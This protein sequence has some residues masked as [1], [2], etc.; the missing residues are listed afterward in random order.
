MSFIRIVSLL[1][2]KYV[3]IENVPGMVSLFKGK[4][5]DEII[6]S[7][8]NLGYTV[9]FQI[10]RASEYG[11]P[12][13]RRR[14][15]FIGSKNGEKFEFPLSTHKEQEDLIF[16]KMVSTY[17]AL[18]DLPILEN[19][20]GEI[21]QEYTLPIKN[22]YQELM[23]VN[24]SKVL[25]HIAANH[26]EKVKETIKLVPPGKNYKALPEEL[27]NS[28][29]FNVAWTRFPDHAPSPTIDTGHRHHFHYSANRVPTV[30]EC[31]RL[32]SFPDRFQFIGNKTE[33]FRQVG[34][35]V[36]PLLAQTLAKKILEKL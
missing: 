32:Q 23:R 14:V 33:Q 35:A 4:I 15:F 21:V 36:P 13:H 27:R 1:N 5:K 31:A 24:S 34:N 10:L 6:K 16:Q 22:S 26:S 18:H 2:P 12:Q 17:D 28:R 19:E 25:N 7:L 20:L 8:E 9:N 30:R 3:L 11:V 29:N